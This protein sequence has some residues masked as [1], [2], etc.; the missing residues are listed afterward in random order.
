MSDTSRLVLVEFVLQERGPTE[1]EAREDLFM[2]VVTG[3]RER[4]AEQ[5]RALLAQA[6]LQLSW[7]VPTQERRSVLEVIPVLPTQETSQ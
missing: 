7:M 6:D 5:F 4:T 2:L 3:G 1:R